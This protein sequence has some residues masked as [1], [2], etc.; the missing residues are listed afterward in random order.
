MCDARLPLQ[1]RPSD[2]P[3]EHTFSNF[4]SFWLGAI[5]VTMDAA[6]RCL[7]TI[8]SRFLNRR[9]VFAIAA[10]SVLGA[11]ACHI[12]AHLS[13]LSTAEMIH[14]GPSFFTQDTALL[15]FLRVLLFA[16]G[17]WMSLLGTF[18]GSLIVL[19]VLALACINISFYT[20][21]GSELHWRNIGLAGDSSSWSVLLTGLFSL[22]LT[23][24]AIMLLSWVVQDLCFIIATTSLDILKFPFTFIAARLPS[25]RRLSSLRYANVP[26]DDTEYGIEQRYTDDELGGASEPK[27]QPSPRRPYAA[28]KV[29]VYLAVAV[30]LLVQVVLYATRPDE[31]SIVFMSWTL[32][33]LPFMDFAH[34]SPNLANLLPF[35]S[36]GISLDN[37]TALA[38]P[39]PFDW[40]PKDTKLPGFEDWHDDEQH[41]SSAA[42]PLKISNL[43]DGLLPAL[44]GK[45]KDVDVRHIL[46][47]KLESTRKD[48]FPIKKNGQIYDK[49]QN[50]FGNKS[51][52]ESAK[53]RLKTLTPTANF[54]TGDYDDGFDHTEKKRRGGIN[55]NNA[56][57]TGTYTLKSL[58]GTLCGI[59]PLV[60]DF[61]VE[62]RYHVYQPCMAQIFDALN[63]VDHK[64][65]PK[66]DDYRSYKWKSAFMQSVTG[67]YDKQRELMPVLGYPPENFLD[68]EYLHSDEAKFGKADMEDINYYGMPEFAIEDYI[69]DAFTSAK[70]NNERVFLSHLTS[71]AH[72]PFGLPKDEV[73]VPLSKEGELQDL[74]TYTNAIGFVDRW[75]EKVLN[76][77]EETGAAN[78]TLVIFVG[79]HG[80]SIPE[81]GAVTPYYQ[82]NVGNFHV[83]L[84]LSHPKL[85]PVDVNDVVNSYQIL[86]TVLDLLLESDSVGDADRKAVHDLVRN[87]EGQSLLRPLRKSHKDSGSGDWQFTVMNT[88]RAMLGV[89]DARNPQW[90][91]VVPI[92]ADTEW[93]FT[94]LDK[95]PHEAKPLLSFGFRSFLEKIKEENGEEASKW[96]EE[97]AFV[98]R[99]WV[100]DNARRWRYT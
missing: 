45:L 57:T 56:H 44:R 9:Y 65:D 23:L 67:G 26:Q 3:I 90:R 60:A 27:V 11:K 15:L 62:Y 12:D 92:V 98:T 75:L 43:D 63:A 16:P 85:P 1:A 61:N 95:D 7:G 76:V 19:L 72:H 46:L 8:A 94:D 74:S 55:A 86:P 99:W 48:V 51:L 79:D 10:V 52:P 50:T 91:V 58:A 32:P 40:L 13:A 2:S 14:W 70:E 80:L 53:Q 42:D 97:A 4:Q 47:L 20:V 18:F 49:L 71:T 88:G 87:Y 17:R 35:Q 66:T 21:A 77:L 100:D 83:P 34:S 25:R 59:T 37:M 28:W 82:P 30:G 84:V 39:V 24:G 81:T 64:K 89:R 31:S 41:Y 29:A 6:R 5:T 69:R 36:E 38:S 96:V 93:R 73:Y 78:E 68:S 54:V 22:G 33:L